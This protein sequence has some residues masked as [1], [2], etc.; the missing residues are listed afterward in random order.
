MWT[1]P[2]LPSVSLSVGNDKPQPQF[3]SLISGC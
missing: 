3:C 2:V 1:F